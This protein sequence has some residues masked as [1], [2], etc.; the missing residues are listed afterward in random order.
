MTNLARRQVAIRPALVKRAG[1]ARAA[2]ARL[3]TLVLAALAFGVAGCGPWSASEPR[4]PELSGGGPGVTSIQVGT[5]TSAYDSGLLEA[6]AP[7]FEAAHPEYKIRFFAVG[8]GQALEMGRRGDVDVVLV[9]APAAEEAF[10][11]SG[12]GLRR[13]SIMQNDFALAGPPEDPADVRG[14]NDVIAALQLIVATGGRFVSRGDQSGTHARE[15]ALWIWAGVTPEAA[16]Y[17]EVGQGMGATLLIAGEQGAYTLTDRATLTVTGPAARL[18]ELY[19]DDPLLE[20]VYS[21]IEVR[22]AANPA[23]ACALSEWLGSAE[24]A[25]LIET[26]RSENGVALFTPVADG[27]ALAPC[28]TLARGAV[29]AGS[30]SDSDSAPGA[31]SSRSERTESRN[32]FALAWDLLTSGDGYVWEI[33]L[34]SLAISGVALLLATIIGIPIGIVVALSRF[35]GHGTVTALIN[36]GLA[37]PPV[38]AG[39]AA[40]LL[41]SRTGP[42]GPLELLYRPAAIVLAQIVLAGPYIAAVTLAAVAAVPGDVRLQ[43]RGLGATRLQALLLHLREVRGSLI[44]AVAAGFGAV[45]SEV[46]AVMIVG[47]NILG[48]TRVMTTAI[49]LE[50]RRGNFGVAIALG[51]ILLAIAFAVNIAL[52]AVGR[53]SL[54]RPLIS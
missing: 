44:A 48:E 46:G 47:G 39:L 13:R 31:G 21:V 1:T 9:H 36:T 51:T 34:R 19:A 22:A 38:V 29:D 4:G 24:G 23:G 18:E 12:H 15:R 17:S 52:L 8:T 42:L 45:I 50:T 2:R 10:V 25:R 11:A 54:R 41:L 49:V 5:T 14:S 6:L 3:A 27:G 35:R 33:V 32:I 30:D 37:L 43:A 7:A 26:F 40:Y 16:R 28:A 53:R 20:N